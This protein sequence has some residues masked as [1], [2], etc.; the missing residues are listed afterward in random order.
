[1]Q[2]L[3]MRLR[4]LK[5]NWPEIRKKIRKNWWKE[6]LAIIALIL[7]I[8]LIWVGYVRFTT[9]GW[10]EWIG[11]VAKILWDLIQLLIIPIAL[12]SCQ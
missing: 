8:L 4:N 1:M 9:G 6:I 5:I 10:P 12:V 11:F 7:M 3:M 2:R